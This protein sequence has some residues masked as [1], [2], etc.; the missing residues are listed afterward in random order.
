[1]ITDPRE[2]DQKIRGSLAPCS[3]GAWPTPLEAAPAL[4][5]RAGVDELWLKRE[6]KAGG[7]KVRALEFLLAGATPTTVCV[8]IGGTGSSHCLATATQAARLG[9]RTVLAQFPQPP[10]EMAERTAAACRARA[11]AVVCA[12]SVAGFPL[13]VLR[14]W[15]L[16]GQLGERRWIPG[17]G[18]TP[19]GVIGHFLAGLELA[20]QLPASPDA[21]VA[22]L[23]SS[24]TV[25]GLALAVRALGWETRVIGVRVAPRVVANRRRAM[26]LARGARRILAAIIALDDPAAPFVLDDYGSTYGRPTAAGESARRD[27]GGYGLVLDSTYG[28]KTFAAL[29]EVGSRGFRRVVFWHTFAVPPVLEPS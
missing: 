29:P 10:S 8:T 22:P 16:A 3:L 1:M 13:A 14:A 11:A 24:G 17:G 9:A 23:G 25:A 28:A 19:R 2:S 21:I 6:D 4:A 20:G 5:G 27:S 26:A 12:G 15:R 18:A 7:S